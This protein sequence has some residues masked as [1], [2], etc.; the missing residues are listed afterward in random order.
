VD[1]PHPLG[2]L[3]HSDGDALIHA[4]IDA[5]LGAIGGGDIGRLFPNTDPAYRGISSLVLLRQVG[6]LVRERGF[7]IGHLDATVVLEKPRLT[8]HIPAMI[9]RLATTLG[10]DTGRV[11]IKAKT[12]EGMGFVGRGEGVAVFAVAAVRRCAR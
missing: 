11:N 12:N 7:E 2:L 10:L 9:E 6:D 3:G 8:A 4:C 5:L 1:I